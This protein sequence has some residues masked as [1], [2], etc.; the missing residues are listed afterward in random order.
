[1]RAIQN[2]AYHFHRFARAL[3]MPRVE[4]IYVFFSITPNF[5]WVA[6]VGIS[7]GA[8]T[9]V[10]Q[11]EES[12]SNLL[13][14]EVKLWRICVPVLFARRVEALLH[15]LF[16]SRYTPLYWRYQELA[17]T[18]GHTE[19]FGYLN[20]VFSIIVFF[21][22]WYFGNPSIIFVIALLL[23]IPI[24]FCIFVLLICVCQWAA[25]VCGLWWAFKIIFVI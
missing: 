14:R 25:I 19:W 5:F 4:H 12:V 18:S 24:D 11:V 3:N 23:P 2:I 9:R 13:R 16:R 17:G 10:K 21:V 6:K 22:W 7:Q 1:M 20:P 8:E 15:R